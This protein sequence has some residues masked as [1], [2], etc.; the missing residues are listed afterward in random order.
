M[1]RHKTLKNIIFL[2]ILVLTSGCTT[3]PGSPGYITESSSLFDNSKSIN[4]EPAWLIDGLRGSDIKL[5]LY[6]N[7][8]MDENMV[9]LIALVMGAESIA[10][11]T[12]LHFKIDD[13]IVSF[14]SIDTLTDI[15][16]KESHGK[17]YQ[18]WSSK[19]YQITIDFLK[20]IIEAEKVIVKLDLA[21]TYAEGEFSTD[22]LTTARPAFRKFLERIET[23][24]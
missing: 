3:L 6:K 11:D 9:I 18:N 24:K 2:T 7:S 8:K 23:L 10:K 1:E 12:S 14:S 21:K 13:Q 15:E 17:Y 19:R 16:T 22:R 20:R 5:S 4:I